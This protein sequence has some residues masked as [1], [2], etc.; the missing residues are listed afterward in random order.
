VYGFVLI[1]HPPENARRESNGDLDQVKLVTLTVL[2]INSWESVQQEIL[3][4][5]VAQTGIHY[6]RCEVCLSY[7][8]EKSLY[9]DN[10]IPSKRIKFIIH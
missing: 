5:N 4:E 9:Y 3:P 10:K 2:I 8:N 1:F 6:Y 7:L